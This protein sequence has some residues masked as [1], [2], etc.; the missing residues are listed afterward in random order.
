MITCSDINDYVRYIVCGQPIA[1]GVSF[2]LN[3]QS[4]S[5][6][7]LLNATWQKSPREPDHRLRFEMEETTLQMRYDAHRLRAL[8][9]GM[10]S[11]VRICALWATNSCT[12]DIR[13]CKLMELWGTNVCAIH[14]WTY[15]SRIY[16]VIICLLEICRTIDIWICG[17]WVYVLYTCKSNIHM[18]IHRHTNRCHVHLCAISV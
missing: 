10:W 1:F 3:L 13:I 16:D 7:S 17:R 14:L 18:E 2:S 6:W 15:N 8:I 11:S 12:I 5:Y 9:Y 4:Q